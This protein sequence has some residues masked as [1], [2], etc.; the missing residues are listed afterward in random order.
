MDKSRKIYFDYLRVF[1]MFVV[2][3]GHVVLA[4]TGRLNVK[5][6]NWQVL[7]FYNGSARWCVPMFFMMSG[8]LFLKKDIPIKKLYSK[9]IFR[10]VVA[11]FIWSILYA[12]FTP[13]YFFTNVF[14]GHYHMWF[15]FIMI[16]VYICIPI[17][18]AIVED[19]KRMEYF[20]L[21]ALFFSFL[22]PTILY[23]TNDFHIKYLSTFLYDIFKFFDNFNIK[24][25][26][27]YIGYFVLGYYM[28]N[29]DISKK[30]RKY[31]YILGIVGF[32]STILLNSIVSIKNLSECVTYSDNFTINIL[33]ESIC[34]FTFF[35]Y[36]RIDNE[37]FNNYVTK[38]SKY[39]FG[40]YLVH[41]FIVDLFDKKFGL[42]AITFNP[43]IST[44]ICSISI[45]IVSC[46]ISFIISKIHVLNKYM[47]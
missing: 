37:K 27:G 45:Y 32:I 19:K 6:F 8:A 41:P 29:Y 38:L 10:L 44:L 3:L 7:N 30:Q 31:I 15:L 20:L 34:A 11:F 46:F 36:L 13:G 26:L 4:Y 14:K 25:V 47:I 18:K 40:I 23:L 24:I 17:V 16:G 9:Y 42:C 2:I 33:F 12:L 21:V 28:D 22:V 43:I 1:S 39:C 35:K 5:S